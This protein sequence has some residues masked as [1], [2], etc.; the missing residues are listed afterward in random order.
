MDHLP[1]LGPLGCVQALP[2]PFCQ[3]CLGSSILPSS[4]QLSHTRKSM[5][6]LS[7]LESFPSSFSPQT[8]QLTKYELF[9]RKPSGTEHPNLGSMEVNACVLNERKEEELWDKQ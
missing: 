5:S 2:A 8:A 7:Y 1:S 9:K 4:A 6:P 3:S